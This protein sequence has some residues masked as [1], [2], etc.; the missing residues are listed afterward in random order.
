MAGVALTTHFPPC[1]NSLALK[2]SVGQR[3]VIA[4]FFANAAV[5][6]LSAGVVV[7]FFANRRWEEFVAFSIWGVLLSLTFLTVS[8]ALTKEVAT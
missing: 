7:P 6:W 4:E 2:L 1:Y 3:R 8:V 5:A